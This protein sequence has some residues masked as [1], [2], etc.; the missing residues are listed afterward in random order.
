MMADSE[1]RSIA[2]EEAGGDI[3]RI[4]ST[5]VDSKQFLEMIRESVRKNT[6]VLVRHPSDV[7]N[8][9]HDSSSNSSPGSFNAT[10]HPYDAIV[11]SNN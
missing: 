1:K 11:S 4:S 5:S 9:N 8:N 10:F 2:A 3:T 6:A 7:N